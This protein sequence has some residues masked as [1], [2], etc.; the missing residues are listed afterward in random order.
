MIRIFL[1][2]DHP[3]LRIG[4][5]F[6]LDQCH[7]VK[8]VGE[9]SDGFHAVERIQADPPDV[10]LVDLDMPGMSGIKVIRILRQVLPDLIMLVLSTYN[11]ENYV[12]DA[13]EA[14]ADGYLLKAVDVPELVRILKGLC[15]KQPVASPYLLNLAV[16]SAGPPE[17][18]GTGGEPP[19]TFREQEVL[20]CIYEG[21]SNKEISN[22]LNISLETVKSHT[23]NIYKK[24]SVRNRLQ[25]AKRATRMRA[26]G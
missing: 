6:S 24:L 17:R 21:Q 10:A 13:M 5:R 16:G 1:A 18:N 9:A 23:R 26:A 4:L 12:R 14:G 8:L 7:D 19:L 2:D 15:A 25:A 22:D 3:L 11:D 20:H